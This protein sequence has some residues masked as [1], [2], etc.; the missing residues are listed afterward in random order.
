[1]GMRHHLVHGYF[2]VDPDV[3]WTAIAE[4]IPDSR[5]ES[6]LRLPRTPRCNP[7]SSLGVLVTISWS[8]ASTETVSKR[9]IRAAS[10]LCD[11]VCETWTCDM[12]TLMVA[13][14][15]WAAIGLCASASLRAQA[16]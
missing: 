16:N 7:K 6:G 4:G 1:I 10:E 8:V 2:D 13:S 11:G 9:T 14:G 12:R 15:L 3:V 5:F